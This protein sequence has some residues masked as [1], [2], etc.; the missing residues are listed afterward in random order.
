MRLPSIFLISLFPLG[1]LFA[2]NEGRLLEIPRQQIDRYQVSTHS[3]QVEGFAMER[4]R[5][6]GKI[7]FYY[8]PVPAMRWDRNVD[9]ASAAFAN[10]FSPSMRY[11]VYSFPKEALGM[12]LTPEALE[13]Y[14][15]S[16]AI[17]F[18]ELS[19]KIISPP[20]QRSGP[21]RFRIFGQRAMFFSYSFERSGERIVRGE[22][23]A[24][25]DD[26]IHVV[27]IEAKAAD[28]HHFFETVRQAMNSMHYAN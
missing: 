2:Q 5:L 3:E 4:V 25:V 15:R 19:F 22:N 18:A 13:A 21:A 9:T 1:I 27:L 6:T 12:S 7:D 24:E 8:D 28:F 16:R 23:W 26:I 17:E 11:E 14:L 10:R 20:A